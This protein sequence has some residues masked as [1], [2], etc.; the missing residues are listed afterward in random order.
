MEDDDYKKESF[1]YLLPYRHLIKE[2]LEEPFKVHPDSFDKKEK[3]KR[4]I[5]IL[6]LVGLNDK[7]L[8][9]FPHEFR[10]I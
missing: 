10:Q 2:L 9:K 3:D 6:K 8:L 1:K 5:K 7:S 4:I